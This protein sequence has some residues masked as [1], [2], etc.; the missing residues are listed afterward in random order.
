M[1]ACPNFDVQFA[2]STSDL[3]TKMQQEVTSKGGTFQGN[4]LSGNISISV[5]GIG[6]II[7]SYLINQQTIT[8]SITDKP[9]FIPCSVIESQ[10][11][12]MIGVQ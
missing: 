1:A 5:P 2:G 8:L 10:I 7:G 4:D 6:N 9:F 12:K 11:T 3:I